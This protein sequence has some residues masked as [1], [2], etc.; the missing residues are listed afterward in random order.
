MIQT[1]ISKI[2]KD[3]CVRREQIWAIRQGQD[4]TGYFGERLTSK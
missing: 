1:K 3:F 4:G 2:G